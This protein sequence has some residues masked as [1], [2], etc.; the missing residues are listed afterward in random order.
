MTD[1]KII[2]KSKNR[3]VVLSY[4]SE[5]NEKDLKQYLDKNKYINVMNAVFNVAA[6]DSYEIERV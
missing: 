1:Y 4:N 5:L 3:E 6:W 2:L